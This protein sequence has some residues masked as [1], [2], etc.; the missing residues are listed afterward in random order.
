MDLICYLSCVFSDDIKPTGR[1]LG[2]PETV[3]TRYRS[4]L[5]ANISKG[6]EG[7]VYLQLDKANQL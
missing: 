3:N 2:T 7:R 5:Q 1:S 4:F 6:E